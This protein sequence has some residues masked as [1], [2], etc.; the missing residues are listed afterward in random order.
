M[1]YVDTIG[2]WGKGNIDLNAR[3]VV[4]NQN[5]SISTER[6]FSTNIDGVEVLLPT[7]INGTIVSEST[8]INHYLSTGEYLG[9]FNTVAEANAYANE[10]HKR[11][12]WY[13]YYEAKRQTAKQ[14]GNVVKH[15]YTMGFRIDDTNIPDPS[16]MTYQ[17]GDLDTSGA[18]DATGLLHRAYVATKINYELSW[19]SLDWDMLQT[20][21]SAVNKAKFRLTAIDP[22]TFNTMYTGDYYVGDRTGDANYYLVEKDDLAQFGLKLKLIEY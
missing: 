12:E 19:N 8:A 2:R 21:L 20:I 13:Y 6:S 9:K 17:V 4:H 16:K 18:R 22:R 1:Y 5:G 14:N 10:L 7:V 3:Q 11:Q 15:K